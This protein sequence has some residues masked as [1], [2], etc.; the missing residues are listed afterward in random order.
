MTLGGTLHYLREGNL[1]VE[2]PAIDRW[3]VSNLSPLQY[4]RAYGKLSHSQLVGI[5][6]RLFWHHLAMTARDPTLKRQTKSWRKN[7]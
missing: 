7:P 4:S 1:E 6:H 3:P 2:V 5:A